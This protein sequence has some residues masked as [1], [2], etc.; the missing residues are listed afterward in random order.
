MSYSRQNILKSNNWQIVLDNPNWC[1]Q[2]LRTYIQT[3]VIY[4]RSRSALLDFPA[5]KQP[6]QEL[7]NF[8]FFSFSTY[9]ILAEDII[10]RSDD[11]FIISIKQVIG[12]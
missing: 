11:A 7:S 5:L 9:I 10:Y 12:K 8:S 2:G 3:P 1:N 6:A 4:N